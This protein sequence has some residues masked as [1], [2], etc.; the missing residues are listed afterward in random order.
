MDKQNVLVACLRGL[1]LKYT[2]QC[3][4]DRIEY[5]KQKGPCLDRVAVFTGRSKWN[6]RRRYLT[7]DSEDPRL[8][9]LYPRQNCKGNG[10]MIQTGSLCQRS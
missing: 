1:N 2:L 7:V 9:S 3:M 4:A 5:G 8:F 10:T 6:S